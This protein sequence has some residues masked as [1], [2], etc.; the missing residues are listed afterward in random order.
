MSHSYGGLEVGKGR[1]GEKIWCEEFLKK[2]PWCPEVLSPHPKGAGC[3]LLEQAESEGCR[4]SHRQLA[5]SPAVRESVSSCPGILKSGHGLSSCLGGREKGSCCNTIMNLHSQ[6]FCD[7]K[8]ANVSCGPVWAL[9]VNLRV[10]R[11]T[12]LGL[13]H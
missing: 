6:S 9:C 4:E 1:D 11:R 12:F 7:N 10:H 13:F 8:C 5:V 2:E 3:L